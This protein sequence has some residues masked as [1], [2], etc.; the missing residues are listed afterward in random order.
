MKK[1]I[2][3][4]AITLLSA[5][6]VGQES[7]N[8]AATKESSFG[9]GVKFNAGASEINESFVPSIF[10]FAPD[11]KFQFAYNF[12]ILT[13][14]NLYDGQYINMDILYN[15]VS[16][17]DHLGEDYI[18]ASGQKIGSGVRDIQ[19]Q[20]NYISIP[21]YY[22]MKFSNW[23]LGA[24]VQTSFAV[25]STMTQ[26][27]NGMKNELPY[28]YQVTTK[29]MGLENPD[30]GPKIFIFYDINKSI[31]IDVDYYHGIDPINDH[32]GYTSQ[33]LTTQEI[34]FGIGYNFAK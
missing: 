30:V 32:S 21:I 5:I 24:G 10:N 6:A 11:N 33:S 9:F 31:F 7:M 2:T 19:R 14:Y 23:R 8:P 12:G 4:T 20:I 28:Y 17:V 16:G 18:T 13:N 25:S 15:N 1:L 29:N 3:I 34:T 22:T 26:T 27:Y